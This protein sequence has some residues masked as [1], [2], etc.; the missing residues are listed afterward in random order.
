MAI[1]APDSTA[2]APATTNTITALP[3]RERTTAS[4]AAV[5][6]II[7]ANL[8]DH[9]NVNLDLP[10]VDHH[11]SAEASEQKQRRVTLTDAPAA[12]SAPPPKYQAAG[13]T[14][15]RHQLLKAPLISITSSRSEGNMHRAFSLRR[16]KSGAQAKQNDRMAAPPM[17]T[18]NHSVTYGEKSNGLSPGQNGASGG[19][20]R[21][22]S[23][24][25]KFVRAITNPD[26]IFQQD[27]SSPP[28]ESRHVCTLSCIATESKEVCP[29][30]S[31]TN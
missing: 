25:Q 1:P 27:P 3:V 16:S 9:P 5:T 10:T 2:A 19:L 29:L 18:R 14:P 28:P 4:P 30:L 6:P 26:K 7:T 21:S 24:R 12:E 15:G 13:S 31:T 23:K 8:Q 22:M 11:E 20:Q 17:H